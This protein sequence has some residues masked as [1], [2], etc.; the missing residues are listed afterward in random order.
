MA[1]VEQGRLDG[2][3]PV[4]STDEIGAVAEGFNRM[5]RGLR[6]R[7]MVKETFGKYVTQRSATRS[8]PGAC[9]ARASSSRP[10]C[11]SPTCATSPRGWRPPSRARWCAT[12]TRTSPRWTGPSAPTAASCCS[13][14]ATRSRRCSARP[15]PRPTT[16]GGRCA[17]RSRCGGASR[18]GTRGR[19]GRPDPAAQRHR[20][21]HRHR[22]GR[23]HRRRRAALLRAGRRPGQPRLAHPGAHQGLQGGHPDQRRHPQPPRRDDRVEELPTVRVKG[24]VEEVNVYKVV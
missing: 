4:V 20:H 21:P 15:S 12:S 18:P 19:G 1:E 24:R 7:E 13:S 14:S 9:A 16:P 3:A 23:Q 6:E 11:C 8:W 10:P 5:L 22:A 2:R 17:P